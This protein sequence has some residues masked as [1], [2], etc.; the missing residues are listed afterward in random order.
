MNA[1]TQ[2]LATVKNMR[3]AEARGKTCFAFSPTTYEQCSATSG[4]YFMQA[5][6][7][8]LRDSEG[9]P[10]I[11]AVKVT[12]YLDALTGDDLIAGIGF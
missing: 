5:D 10:M 7:E 6:D 2:T 8:P 1:D 11:L 4:D 9:E 3:E 12:R